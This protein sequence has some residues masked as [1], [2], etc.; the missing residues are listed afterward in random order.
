MC[1]CRSTK[2]KSYSFPTCFRRRK[3]RGEGENG[4]KEEK[5]EVAEK[6]VTLENLLFKCFCSIFPQYFLICNS[7]KGDDADEHSEQS[8]PWKR[9]TKNAVDIDLL[10]SIAN[11]S[12]TDEE[13]NDG[14]LF[15]FVATP[16]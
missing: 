14:N 15:F 10:K 8:K 3:C 6:E 13:D 9:A 4:E 7:K 16:M 1:V 2:T 12:D 5:E 11:K